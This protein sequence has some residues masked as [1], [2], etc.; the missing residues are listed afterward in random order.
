MKLHVVTVG[1]YSD[2]CI[3]GILDDEEAAKQMV[4]ELKTTVYGDFGVPYS[5]QDAA[6]TT[7]ELNKPYGDAPPG[8]KR[9]LVTFDGWG[10]SDKCD[11]ELCPVYPGADEEDFFGHYLVFA[12]SIE[13][14]IKVASERRF[15]DIALG[16]NV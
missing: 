8:H 12:T 4:H 13:H 9:Y 11:V 3:V 10:A 2:K 14:A 5:H 15:Q 7:Y 6:Y 16:K 1:C